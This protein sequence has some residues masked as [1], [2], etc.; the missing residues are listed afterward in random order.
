MKML[1]M[2]TMAVCLGVSGLWEGTANAAPKSQ[3]QRPSPS[4]VPSAESQNNQGSNHI[5]GLLGFVSGMGHVSS[6]VF[7]FGGDYVRTIRPNLDVTAGVLRWSNVYSDSN[8][9][10]DFAM[11]TLDGGVEYRIPIVENITLKGAARLGMGLASAATQDVI[12]G[13]AESHSSTVTAFAATFGGSFIYNTGRFQLGA[14]IRKPIFFAKLQDEGSF[15][16]LMATGT[17]S[18]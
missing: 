4:S 5:R 18:L 10:I 1:I 12:I 7:V 8:Y 13:Q 14:E 9:S 3:K 15:V 11:T 16:Y 17:Y 2:I 6:A